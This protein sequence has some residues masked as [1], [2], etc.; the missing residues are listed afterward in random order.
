MG[1]QKVLKPTSTAKV[2]LFSKAHTC[3]WYEEEKVRQ[4]RNRSEVKHHTPYTVT[5]PPVQKG[6]QARLSPATTVP[7]MQKH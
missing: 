2:C 3:E 4:D 6:P 1:S 5:K 7:F